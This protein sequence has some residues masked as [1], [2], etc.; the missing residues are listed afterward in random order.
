MR[1]FKMKKII[2]VSLLAISLLLLV[3]CSPSEPELSEEELSAELSDL[4]AEDPVAYTDATTEGA[5]AGQATKNPKTRKK[6]QK[7]KKALKKKTINK[8]CRYL[9][10]G[11]ID[12]GYFG[13]KSAIKYGPECKGETAVSYSCD[14]KTKNRIVDTDS[15]E[16]GCS[17]GKC[18]AAAEAVCGNGEMEAGEFCDGAIGCSQDCE[19]LPGFV[20]SV[21]GC[22]GA[23]G[24]INDDNVVN[25][26]DGEC[27]SDAFALLGTGQ[28]AECVRSPT[29]VSDLN[30]DGVVGDLGD[31]EAMV[32]FL[33]EG[34]WGA[35][36]S[37]N[38]G[39]PNCK[40]PCID[41][42]DGRNMGIK[43]ITTGMLRSNG[44]DANGNLIREGEI[45]TLED[46]CRPQVDNRSLTQYSCRDN[47]VIY[48]HGACHHNS[49]TTCQDGACVRG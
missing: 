9:G 2:L 15:C 12:Y 22:Y 32:S 6:V 20:C 8:Y 48:T 38:D 44:R 25:A 10:E 23:F 13:K 29:G 19:P 14:K 37:N 31:H 3:A 35:I 30:C 26:A 4:E 7:V 18:N 21:D 11:T 17:D 42:D 27:Y 5:L 1:F 46:R 34:T 41:S 43:G 33:L 47:L 39:I 28:A 16:N 36:D 45:G 40:I 49:N 24:D